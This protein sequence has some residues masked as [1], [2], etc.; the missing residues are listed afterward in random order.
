MNIFLKRHLASEW[1]IGHLKGGW[2]LLMLP[3]SACASLISSFIEKWQLHWLLK[4]FPQRPSL[5]KSRLNSLFKSLG[6]GENVIIWKLETKMLMGWPMKGW[7]E[8]LKS[9]SPWE[10]Q[11]TLELSGY[12]QWHFPRIFASFCD[13]G[14]RTVFVSLFLSK[15]LHSSNSLASFTHC[16]PPY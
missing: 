6:C 7:N 15:G 13:K 9:L 4:I 1:Q 16:F 3:L 8:I 14:Q 2:L 11:S 5:Q 10:I 12:L